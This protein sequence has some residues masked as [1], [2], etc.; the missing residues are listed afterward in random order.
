MTD[1]TDYRFRPV[2]KDP[3]E[4]R[5]VTLSF[6]AMCANFWVA[7]EQFEVSEIVRPP[8]RPTGFAYQASGGTSGAREPAWPR[9]LGGTVTDGSV[10]W[11]A[12]AAGVNGLL[13]IEDE[14]QADEETNTLSMGT[15]I[16]VES[17]KVLVD[18]TGGVDGED[19]VVKYT[20]VV[21]GKTRVARQLVR[22]RLG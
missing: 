10:T 13:P 4:T 14:P 12:I 2:T 16:V 9:R 3:A 5:S 19:Y 7:N 15:P 17:V 11:T 18:Y 8:G 20:I 1:S 22:V 21:N 6:Y